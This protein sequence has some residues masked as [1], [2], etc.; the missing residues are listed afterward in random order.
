M[1][2]IRYGVAMSLDG[3]I[4]GPNGEADWIVHDPEVNFAE[5][6]EQFDTFLMGR[7][8]YEPAKARVGAKFAGNGKVAVVSRTLQQSDEPTV[9]IINELTHDRIQNLRDRSKKDIWLFGGGVL[10]ASLHDMGEVD[11]IDVSVMPVLLGKGIS[12]VSSPNRSVQLALTGH[13]L[14]RSGIVTL[15]YDVKK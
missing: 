5:I 13:K 8:T 4:A 11:A 14:Y 15:H 2:R 9:E 10:F 6:W 3:F 1:P 12:F 7:G